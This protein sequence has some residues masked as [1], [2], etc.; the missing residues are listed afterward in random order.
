MFKRY[1]DDLILALLQLKPNL[2]YDIATNKLVENEEMSTDPGDKYTFNILKSIADSI[3][4]QIQW[5]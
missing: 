3:H 1:V 4:P 2:K 5:K